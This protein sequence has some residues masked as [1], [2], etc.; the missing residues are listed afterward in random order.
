[1]CVRVSDWNGVFSGGELLS[2]DEGEENCYSLLLAN[3]SV[4][5]SLLYNSVS[6]IIHIVEV[7][8]STGHNND[9]VKVGWKRSSCLLAIRPLTKMSHS[10]TD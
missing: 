1:M 5:C 7:T 4:L 2:T 3:D 8:R 6:S 9:N 10:G